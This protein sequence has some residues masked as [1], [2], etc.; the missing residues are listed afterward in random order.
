M[1]PRLSSLDQACYFCLFAPAI[2]LGLLLSLAMYRSPAQAPAVYLTALPLAYLLGAVPAFLT[3]MVAGRLPEWRG[4]PLLVAAL[5]ALIFALSTLFLLLSTDL[6]H[7]P[8]ADTLAACVIIGFVA[9][10]C[11]YLLVGRLPALN[12]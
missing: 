8:L 5:G 1:K 12:L 3:G 4:K 2:G 9:A 10:F 6:T 11:V 7:S